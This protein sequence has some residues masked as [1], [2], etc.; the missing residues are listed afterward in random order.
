[1]TIARFI[2]AL[3]LAV[4]VTLAVAWAPLLLVYGSGPW[5]DWTVGVNLLAGLALGSITIYV[6][7]DWILG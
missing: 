3:G 6:L 7:F 5:P 2:A 4:I 1:M